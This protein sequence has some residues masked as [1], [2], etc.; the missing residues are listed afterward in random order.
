MIE[1]QIASSI[2]KMG[3]KFPVVSVSGPRQSGKSTLIKNLF[4]KYNYINLE[5]IDVRQFAADDPRGFLNS[6]GKKVIIDEVQRVPVLFN[7]IQGIVDKE[8]KPGQFILSGSQNFLLMES[9]TQSLAG[10]VAI[11]KLLPF[12]YQEVKEIKNKPK[13]ANEAIFK[14]FYPRIYDKKIDPHFFYQSYIET[15]IERDLRNLKNIGDLS[16][17]SK[18]LRLCAGR[19]GQ[20]LNLQSLAQDAGISQPTA[21]SWLSIL[22]T[23]FIIFQ[24]APY[25]A[26]INKRLIKSPKIYFYD[27]GL[28]SYLLGIN[29]AKQVESHYLKGA[30]FENLVVSELYKLKLNKGIEPDFNFYRDSNGNEIDL[31]WQNGGK[32]EKLEI[33][34][35]STL[36]KDFIQLMKKITENKIL[37]TGKNYLVLNST[38][39]NKWFD[40]NVF[41]WRDLKI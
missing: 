32:L 35:S 5:D 29:N 3:K 17:F 8:N 12:S 37:P 24:L 39:I 7:Y 6:I 10:R 11:F 1:R 9:I 22:E 13:S 15:Y 4:T 40:V 21:K 41:D 26:N 23:S 36:K 31:V 25:H 18:F 33:K 20:L 34:F 27:T 2:L 28:A 38:E 16:S 14:G 19:C 30:L